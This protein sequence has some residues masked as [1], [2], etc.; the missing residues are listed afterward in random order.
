MACGQSNRGTVN[1]DE[2]N[3][4]ARL[5]SAVHCALAENLG[6]HILPN[7]DAISEEYELTA[8]KDDLR[9]L[10]YTGL[11]L[12]DSTI[13]DW[14]RSP[15]FEAKLGTNLTA[16]LGMHGTADVLEHF[17]DERRAVVLDWKTDRNPGKRDYLPQVKG[18]AYLTVV[19]FPNTDTV[20]VCIAYLRDK[21][22]VTETITAEEA[23]AFAEELIHIES[24]PNPNFVVGDHC[25]YCPRRYNCQAL[26]D[27]AT[28]NTAIVLAHPTAEPPTK[29]DDIRR[30]WM[31]CR[32]IERAVKAAREYCKEQIRRQIPDLNSRVEC[33]GGGSLGLKETH[34]RTIDP[35]LGIQVATRYMDDE[36][37]ATAVKLSRPELIK[38][39][40][41]TAPDGMTKKAREEEFIAALQSAGAE[42]DEIRY[43]ADIQ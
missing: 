32:D 21:T 19:N 10:Y 34:V 1:I 16:E 29:P 41:E 15:S 13:S 12:W 33:P 17:P 27:R 35:R 25:E 8:L 2:D 11:K 42:L 14:F 28:A 30:L 6:A 40:R 22:F 38:R 7:F 39:A 43:D 37:L 5:G 23:R 9:S 36:A 20:T 3:E 31:G 26:I 24:D 4:S 18:Y